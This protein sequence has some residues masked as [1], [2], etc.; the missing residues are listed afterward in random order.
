MSKFGKCGETI[1]EIIQM[2]TFFFFGIHYMDSPYCLL[3]LLS[4]SVF[5]F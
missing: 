2:K 1:S 3:L 5:T 4:I